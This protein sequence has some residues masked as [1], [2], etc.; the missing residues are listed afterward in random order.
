MLTRYNP[1]TILSREVSEMAEKLAEKLETKLFKEK[2]RDAVA[3]KEAQI[4]QK[5]LFKYAPKSNVT[6]DYEEFIDEFL[7]KERS[8]K[9][10]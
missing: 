1:R 2:I 8:K 7:G 3:V 9:N 5:S 10:G 6:K 4:S